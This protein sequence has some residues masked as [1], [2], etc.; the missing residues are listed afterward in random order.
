MIN[1]ISL[2]VMHEVLA[3]CRFE[4]GSKI[5]SWTRSGET[6]SGAPFNSIT[7]TK[8]EISVVMTQQ[9]I[10]NNLTNCERGWRAIRVDGKLDFSLCG[11]ISSLLDRLSKVS[12]S[13]FV[14]STY[15]TD[16]ILVKEQQLD[17]A[18][19][20]LREICPVKEENCL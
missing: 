8:D 15:D 6:R 4:P 7:Y 12:V 14:L 16:Y 9:S 11:I 5:P 10:P 3:V 20:N 13:V 1:Q 19:K 18:I 17:T 2:T